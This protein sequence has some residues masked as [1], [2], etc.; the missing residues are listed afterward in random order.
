MPKWLH[1]LIPI[2]SAGVITAVS[3]TLTDSIPLTVLYGT[4]SGIISYTITETKSMCSKLE[5]KIN[6]WEVK[7]LNLQH[8]MPYIEQTHP[9]VRDQIESSLRNLRK[10]AD[11]V[12]V[13][14]EVVLQAHSIQRDITHLLDQV[15]SG[16]VF[17]S[18]YLKPSLFWDTPEGDLYGQKCFEL[19]QRGVKFTRIFIK[20]ARVDDEEWQGTV[21]EIERQRAN[22]VRVKIAL[23][24]SLPPD[25]RKDFLLIPDEYVSYAHMGARGDLLEQVRVCFSEEE[26]KTAKGMA[27]EIERFSTEFGG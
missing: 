14:N 16:D 6:E 24:S 20:P 17:A 22:G 8:I 9:Y 2:A 15:K 3:Y 10:L 7:V 12:A 1:I 13:K 19:V 21:R 5:N 23:E 4:L 18:S 25:S 27:Q 26:L 11:D